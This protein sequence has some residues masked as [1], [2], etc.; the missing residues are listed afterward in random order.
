MGIFF[1]FGDL[2]LTQ[3]FPWPR[4]CQPLL[5]SRAKDWKVTH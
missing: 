3:Y 1:I 5:R 2:P 4:F